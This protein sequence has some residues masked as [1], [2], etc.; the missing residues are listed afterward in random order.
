M[1]NIDPLPRLPVSWKEFSDLLRASIP[2][3][4]DVNETNRETDRI[5]SVAEATNRLP[6]EKLADR[7]SSHLQNKEQRMEEEEK[8]PIRDAIHQLRNGMPRSPPPSG[9]SDAGI[10][11]LA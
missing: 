7:T 4:N 10:D 1:I 11:V 2:K 8:D 3:T 6:R 5:S 9:T